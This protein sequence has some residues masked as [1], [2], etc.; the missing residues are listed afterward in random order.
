[1]PSDKHNSITAKAMGLIFFLFDVALSLDVPFGTPQHV[2]CIL[3]GLTSVLL[4]VSFIFAHHEKCQFCGMHVMASIFVTEIVC[5]FHS[6]YFDCRGSFQ[7]VI[8]SYCCIM[9]WT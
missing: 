4:C 8:D 3:Q 6:G 5:N 1:M 7:T 9:Y 2:Q